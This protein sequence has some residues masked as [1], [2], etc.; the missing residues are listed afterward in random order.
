M[1]VKYDYIRKHSAATDMI[2]YLFS[3]TSPSQVSK[4]MYKLLQTLIKGNPYLLSLFKM[5]AYFI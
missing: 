3:F 2:Q 5:K 4:L 1:K